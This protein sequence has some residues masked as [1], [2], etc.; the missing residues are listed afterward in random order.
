[1]KT[2]RPNFFVVGAAKAG[3]TSL[4]HY[5][6][7]HPQ[8]YMSPVKEPNH[9]SYDT[10]LEKLRPSARKRLKALNIEGFLQGD[11]SNKIHRAYITDRQQYISL[12]R[13]AP[14]D[15]IVGEASPAY[16]YSKVAAEEIHQFNPEA[17]IV[18]ILRNPVERAYSHYLMDRKLA[19]TDKSFE[20]ALTD[21]L[22]F[23]PRSWGATSLYLDLGEYYQQVKRYYDIFPAENIL[24]LLSEEL[25]KNTAETISKLY[26]FL[27][28]DPSFRPNLSETHNKA[29]VPRNAL[30]HRLL[31][32]SGLRVFIR[33]KINN[34]T[35]K[36]ILRKAI[37][38]PPKESR[39]SPA[40]TEKL[41]L[42]FR[43]DI[44]QL[45]KLIE[46]DLTHWL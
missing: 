10:D 6:E 19:F 37:F 14:A 26:Q 46:K 4:Y 1:M 20:E 22:R 43:N 5:L 23:T 17:K 39:P 24:V 13:F 21:D 16:L 8:V 31:T 27:G 42:H 41:K 45:S 29:V 15:K 7:Q 3:T 40:I 44:Q 34:G 12:F 32:F 25:R 11:M 35:F 38:N 30:M 2:I 33:R 36:N 9:F 28:I 18:I